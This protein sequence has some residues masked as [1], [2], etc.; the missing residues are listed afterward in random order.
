MNFKWDYS[1]WIT[2]QHPCFS[3]CGPK[4]T[5]S[6][7]PRERGQERRVKAKLLQLCPALC[8]PMGCS[9]PGSSVQEDNFP[10]KN[11]GTHCHFF[12]Q[13]TYPTQGLKLVSFASPDL[14]DG[15]LTT[16]ITWEV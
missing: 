12:L 16:S 11:T 7:S 6:A 3:M 1:K 15:F 9:S 14:A 13:G 10:G 4:A 8:D 2:S 5:Q